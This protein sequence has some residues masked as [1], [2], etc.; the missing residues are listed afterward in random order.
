MIQS[1]FIIVSC[2]WFYLLHL[3]SSRGR[4]PGVGGGGGGLA[5]GEGDGQEAQDPSSPAA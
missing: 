2:M 4:L 1:P 5:E 3:G